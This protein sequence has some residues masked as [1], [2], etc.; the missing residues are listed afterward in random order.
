M[1]EKKFVKS[2]F[3]QPDKKNRIDVLIGRNY[4]NIG[5]HYNDTEVALFASSDDLIRTKE[6]ST[7]DGSIIH[8]TY[9][10][11]TMEFEVILNGDQIDD[12]VTSPEKVLARLKIPYLAGIFW[13]FVVLA[14][15]L[16]F[17]ALGSVTF[18]EI[19]SN[20]FSGEVFYFITSSFVVFVALITGLVLLR[21][22][23]MFL[24]QI[25]FSLVALDLLYG[26]LYQVIALLFLSGGLKLVFLVAVLFSLAFKAGILIAMVKNWKQFKRFA[27]I[28]KNPKAR[29]DAALV[30]QG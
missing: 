4:Q 26:L 21:R 15:S 11:A 18:S 2:F 6:L 22:G 29:F 20:P 5:V 8:L 14:F 7:P 16:R 30:D 27:T 23:S 13:Y 25:V 28:K 24:Y 12:S 10:P 9:L 1:T 3:S 17:S 19:L